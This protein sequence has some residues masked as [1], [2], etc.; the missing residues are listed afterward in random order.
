M[1]LHAAPK[2]MFWYWINERHRIYQ[3]RLDGLPRPWTA[4]TIL[5]RYKFTNVFRELDRGTAWLRENFTQPHWNDPLELIAFNLAWYRMFNW[6]GTGEYLGWQETW[7]PEAVKDKLYRKEGQI[8]TGAHIIHSEPGQSKIE[9]IVDVCS[10]VWAIRDAIKNTARDTRRLEATFKL[11]TT[12]RHIGGFMGY[13]I[14]TDYRHSRLL[15]D[16]IDVRTWAN[17]GPGCIRGLRRLDPEM[18]PSD[19]LGR[20]TYLL[21]ESQYNLE[22]HVPPLEMR[23][24]E[25]SLCEFDKY[26]R[27][28][29]EEG[30]PRSKFPG[31]SE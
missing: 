5:Q 17:P 6:T 23:D 4:D 14:V 13:E 26:C 25:H 12:L 15:L 22:N 21:E 20:M 1:S 8:F 24:I 10:H 27:V 28:Y 3:R 19:A 30:K 16:A 18:R 9:S 11:L 31:A 7:D 29:F 2:S